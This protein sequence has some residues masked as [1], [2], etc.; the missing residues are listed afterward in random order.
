MLFF[1]SCDFH[2]L[3][4]LKY[5][6]II[7][8]FAND[9]IYFYSGN[10]SG[11]WQALEG[12]AAVNFNQGNYETAFKKYSEASTFIEYENNQDKKRIKEKLNDVQECLKRIA[13]KVSYSK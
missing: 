2:Y 1:S 13:N 8:K 10:I 9:L 5:V 12:L 6:A 4:G 11:K 3:Q 7:S